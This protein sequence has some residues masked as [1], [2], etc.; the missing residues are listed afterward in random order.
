MEIQ[1]VAVYID[2]L[3]KVLDSETLAADVL[4]L[5]FVLLVDGLHDEVYQ[6]GTFLAQLLEINLLRIVRAVHRLAVMDEVSHLDIEHEWFFGILY[7]EGV[8]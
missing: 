5:A 3:Q 6:H 1:Q 8:E 2:A 4:H 7:V